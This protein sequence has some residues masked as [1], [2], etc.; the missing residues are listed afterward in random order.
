MFRTKITLAAILVAAGSAGLM[1][2]RALAAHDS[3][4]G[5][6]ASLTQAQSR[7]D[8]WYGYAVSLTQAPQSVAFTTDTLAPGGRTPVETYHFF[9]DTLA[10]GGGSSEAAMPTS[11]E[12]QWGDAGIGAGVMVGIGAVLLGS[13]RLLHRRRAIAV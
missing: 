3:W 7:H 11:N 1:S 4:Y 13:A 12:F 9:T 8:P 10:P 6:A 5:Y 2:H